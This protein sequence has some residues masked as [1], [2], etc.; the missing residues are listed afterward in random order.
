MHLTTKEPPVR[1]HPIVAMPS[2]PMVR[3][4][5][6]VKLPKLSLKKFQ[7]D[8]NG[9]HRRIHLNTQCIRMLH[10]LQLISFAY[11]NFLVEG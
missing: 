7:G 4:A 11:L 5:A 9:P 6:R 2:H 1:E 8:L 10:C 3:T